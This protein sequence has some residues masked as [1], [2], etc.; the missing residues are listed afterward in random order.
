VKEY[1]YTALLLSQ[2]SVIAMKANLFA[3]AI[4]ENYSEGLYLNLIE[5]QYGKKP[6]SDLVLEFPTI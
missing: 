4:T 5:C 3:I 6:T 2:F 1:Y